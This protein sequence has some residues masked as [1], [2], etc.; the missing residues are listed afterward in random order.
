ML[1]SLRAALQ[2]IIDTSHSTFFLLFLEKVLKA[3]SFLKG[4]VAGGYF[5]GLL[6]SPFIVQICLQRGLRPANLSSLLFFLSA[7]C[8]STSVLATNPLSITLLFTLCLIFYSASVPLVTEIYASN[9]KAHQRGLLFSLTNMLRISGAVLGAYYIG[10]FLEATDLNFSHI[11]LTYSVLLLINS[12]F[13]LNYPKTSIPEKHASS[14]KLGIKAIKENSIFRITLICWMIMGFGNLMLLPLRVDFLA[15]PQF[16]L[17]LSPASVAL[18]VAVIPNIARFF[19][20]FWW[21]ILFDRI[22]FFLMRILVNLGF[23]AGVF[24]FFFTS[25][26]ISLTIGSILI[27]LS[28]AGGDVAWN[29]WVTK[30]A[31]PGQNSTYMS[32][33][34]FFTGLRGV[35]APMLGFYI[36][37][38]F[39][40]Y[41]IIIS[42]VSLIILASLILLLNKENA[43]VGSQPT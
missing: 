33:H 3:N 39:G 21:G 14:L 7:I 31:P 28:N 19:F 24:A 35:T 9:Y 27:G 38:R 22:N 37:A 25:S 17:A 23:A 34:T 18:Y 8:V 16:G 30:F 10:K 41:P 42:S 43:P 1:E 4:T 15:N 36:S 29:L 40:F 20:S 11:F 13:F 32:V 2:G 5:Y 6:L 12:I 26:P